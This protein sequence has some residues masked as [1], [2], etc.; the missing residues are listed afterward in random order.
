MSKIKC[1]EIFKYKNIRYYGFRNKK[2]NIGDLGSDG[3]SIFVFIKNKWM[4]INRR[5][6]IKCNG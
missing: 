5:Y 6:W 3:K 4:R 2:P 1:L